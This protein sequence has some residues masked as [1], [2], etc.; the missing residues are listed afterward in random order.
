MLPSVLNVLNALRFI[1]KCAL[2]RFEC[3]SSLNSALN[4]GKGDFEL[5]ANFPETPLVACSSLD[6]TH[7]GLG[8]DL[9]QKEKIYTR[10]SLF[11]HLQ[12]TLHGPI[13][14]CIVFLCFLLADLSVGVQTAARR[15]FVFFCKNPQVT[16]GKES[17]ADGSRTKTFQ[18]TNGTGPVYYTD[19]FFV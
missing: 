14:R 7:K 8:K 16:S 5:L 11:N 3:G 17:L 2:R 6:V 12:S 15:P 13:R 4:V 19:I 1:I 10:H 18:L 9:C